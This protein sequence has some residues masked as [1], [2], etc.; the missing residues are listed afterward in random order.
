MFNL[1]RLMIEGKGTKKDIKRGITLIE[2][3][4]QLPP[5]KSF[6]DL[7]YPNVGVLEA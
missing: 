4:A 7:T 3:V 6:M 2:E 1:G 5:T